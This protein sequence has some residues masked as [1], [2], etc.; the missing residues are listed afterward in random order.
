M[1]AEFEVELAPGLVIRVN[2]P[3][4]ATEDELT[5]KAMQSP[6]YA[7]FQNKGKAQPPVDTRGGDLSLPADRTSRDLPD[8]GTA[9]SL[10]SEMKAGDAS[11]QN[12][13]PAAFKEIE[14]AGSAPPA[15]GSINKKIAEGD[16]EGAWNSLTDLEK[17]S[18]VASV[19]VLAYGGYKIADKFLGK[20]KPSQPT[21]RVEPTGGLPDGGGGQP[22][23]IKSRTFEAGN[24]G[25]QTIETTPKGMSAKEIQV[26]TDIKDRF[27]YDINDLKKQFGVSDIPITDINQ[28]EILATNAR[29]KELAAAET[30]KPPVAETPPPA[31][32]EEIKPA[33]VAETPKAPAPPSEIVPQGAVPPEE[34]KKGG[35]PSAKSMEGTTFRPDLG[36]GDN[37]LYNTA[38]PD[39]RK[40]ILA[41]FNEGKPAKDYETAQKLYKKYQEKYPKDLF[42]PVIPV[43]QAKAR[44][45]KPPENYGQLGKVA[46][47]GGVAGLAL[48]AAEMANAAQKSSKGNDAPLRESIFNLLG[49]IPG[50]G[51]AFSGATYAGGLNENEAA[52]LAR[53]RQMP[54]TITKR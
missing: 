28:A 38:G 32:V 9:E 54:P 34:K 23:N 33:P 45:I 53:R 49:M 14:K 6:K 1:I 37:W 52:D 19:P 51:T 2:A 24:Y 8:A 39:R 20:E 5:A 16:L 27:G 7:A 42:G 15:R 40:A 18:L 13:A 21:V 29:N 36:P 30:P 26:A 31:P 43:E 46:K 41:E 48:T 50:L 17:G 12:A 11:L 25:N 22:N 3:E 47:V 4:D 35:R 44:G 10:I